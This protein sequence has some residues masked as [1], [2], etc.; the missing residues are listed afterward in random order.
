MR[1]TYRNDGT[2]IPADYQNYPSMDT[3]DNQMHFQNGQGGVLMNANEQPGAYTY[4]Y[5]PILP[6]PALRRPPIVKYWVFLIVMLVLFS[7]FLTI[8]P[9]YCLYKMKNANTQHEVDRFFKHA[10]IGSFV[11]VAVPAAI[12]ILA[13]MSIY[14]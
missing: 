8:Y 7:N 2:I 1:Y 12:F 6:E 14:I 4:G 10:R 13:S 11:S 3:P 9:M 5:T